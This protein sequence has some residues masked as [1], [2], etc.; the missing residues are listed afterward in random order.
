MARL[1]ACDAVLGVSTGPTH[2]S[3]ALGVPTLCLMDKSQLNRWRLLGNRAE[4][5][6]YPDEKADLGYGTDRFS[7]DAV[8]TYLEKLRS[9]GPMV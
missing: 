5:L 2:L 1:H 7:F 9:A 4:S 3:A 8:L 6:A